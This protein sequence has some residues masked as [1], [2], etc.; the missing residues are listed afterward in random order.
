[1]PHPVH[2]GVIGCGAIS[3]V[4]LANAKGFESM[5]VVA[6]ADLQPERAKSRA[7]EFGIPR[8]CGVL[9]LIHDPEVEVV[10]N[11]TTPDAHAEIAMASVHAGK[12]VYNEKPLT[13]RRREARRLLGVAE[14]QGL[15]VGCAPDTFMGAGLQACRGVI[16]E[17]QIG[18]PVAAT[19]FMM[20]SGP[21]K[22]HADPEF[23]FKRGAGPLF[24]MGPY[25]ITALVSLLGSVERVCASARK[26]LPTRTISSQPR[27]GE[28]IE[29]EV[30]THVS[31]SLEFE[32]GAIATVVMSFDVWHHSMPPIEIH[33][34]EGS[35]QAPDPNGYGGPVRVRRHDAS[36]WREVPLD[37]TLR[38]DDA[39]GIGLDD[40][41]RCLRCRDGGGRS[42][43]PRASGAMAY[44][45]LEVMHAMADSAEEGRHMAVESR[46]V[47]P[48]RM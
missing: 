46:I 17:G 8:T 15:F 4:Y 20:N 43:T 41:C 38:A 42:G 45:V 32:S 36:G 7:A 35:I 48:E 3:P 21:E 13:I 47:R 26:S 28:T 40:L 25:Y 1:M 34:S 30:P 39:R 16:D 27:A 22:W 18:E 5:K 6:C 11:L 24:D 44:H 2:V 37:P 19:A 14:R 9:E 12:S 33:G 31:G 29:V 10:L 23:Y